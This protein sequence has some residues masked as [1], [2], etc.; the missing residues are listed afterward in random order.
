MSLAAGSGKPT[1]LSAWQRNALCFVFVGII[2]VVGV[3][4]LRVSL[5]RRLSVSSKA[6]GSH[7]GQAQGSAGKIPS[8]QPWVQMVSGGEIDEPRIFVI[9]DLLNDAECEHL[10]ALALSKGLKKSLITPYGSHDLVESSTRTNRQAWLEYGE[11]HIV[12]GIEERIAKL[13]KTYPEQGENMQ[14]QCA[15]P[16]ERSLLHALS[17]ALGLGHVLSNTQRCWPQ[18]QHVVAE[19]GCVNVRALI[20]HCACTRLGTPL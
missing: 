12:K 20:S 15:S 1:R 6:P 4:V 14:V 5:K 8:V 19:R 17:R 3:A 13:T 18:H 10:I 2:Y 7:F 11:D 16:K 9:H